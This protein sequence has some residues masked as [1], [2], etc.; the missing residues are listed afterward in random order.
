MAKVSYFLL[1]LS[2]SFFPLQW[3]KLYRV[4]QGPRDFLKS[5]D[6]ACPLRK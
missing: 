4:S 5:H 2:Y 6:H 3:G 1:N